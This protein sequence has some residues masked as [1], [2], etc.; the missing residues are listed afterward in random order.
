MN[1]NK[2]TDMLEYASG[3]TDTQRKYIQSVIETGSVKGAMKALGA[4]ST[5]VYEAIQRLK[6]DATLH[7]Y[8]SNNFNT[9]KLDEHLFLR[10]KTVHED[11][12]G[13]IKQSWSKIDVDAQLQVQ[14]MQNAINSFC[15]DVK[16]LKVIP[17]SKSAFRKDICASMP[18]ADLHLG[19][20]AWGRE[21]GKDY[22]L[23]IAENNIKLLIQ[24]IFSRIPPCELFVI[25]NLG[26]FFHTDNTDGYTEKSHNI[27][28]RDGR[29]QMM[30]DAG[31]RIL[32]YAI[33]YA[34]SYHKSVHVI[35]CPGNHDERSATMLHSA[36][37]NMYELNDRVTFPEVCKQSHYYIFGKNL[38]AC[39]HGHKKKFDKLPLL[40]AAE[41]PIEWGNSTNRVFH[42]AHYHS[43]K[44]KE[45]A[46][47]RVEAFNSIAN[48]DAYAAGGGWMSDSRLQCILYDIRGG[49][50][51]RVSSYVRN[52]PNGGE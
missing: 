39:D 43:E 9:T 5:R 15:E 2:L 38:I 33:D 6:V 22:D 25:E 44:A 11:A 14:Q 8:D 17:V 47:C 50:Y 49:E 34:L 40:M 7:N 36:L 16:P 10:K 35:N 37:K 19:M 4:S 1:T 23:K 46:G 30:I 18:I 20:L 32:R 27:L 13:N 28:D 26:D 41:K 3:I 42:T 29:S 21:C 51:D 52:L 45:F 31:F 12:E 24:D 48:R